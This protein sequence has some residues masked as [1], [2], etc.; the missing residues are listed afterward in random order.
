MESWSLALSPSMLPGCCYFRGKTIS[1]IYSRSPPY[2]AAEMGIKSTP[3]RTQQPPGDPPYH[4]EPSTA[5]YKSSHLVKL[6]CTG[7]F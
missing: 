3:G 6:R 7:K 4:R 1:Q 5:S 2:R